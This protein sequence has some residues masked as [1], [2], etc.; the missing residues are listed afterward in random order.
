MLFNIKITLHSK[1]I[2]IKNKFF[3]HN[4]TVDTRYVLHAILI[5]FMDST[6]LFYKIFIF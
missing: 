2:S 1:K 6:T 5:G 4:N 3:I